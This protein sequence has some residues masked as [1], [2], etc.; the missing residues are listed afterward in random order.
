[1]SK[2]VMCKKCGEKY[3][4]NYDRAI[5]RDKDSLE[6][7][8]CKEKLYSWN[9]AKLWYIEEIL[10]SDKTSSDGIKRIS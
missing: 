4:I 1:M 2:V 6:C 5:A 7:P 8:K 10:N 3:K 9:E